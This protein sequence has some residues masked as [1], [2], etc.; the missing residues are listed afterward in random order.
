[1][2]GIVDPGPGHA[3]PVVVSEKPVGPADR[4]DQEYRRMGLAGGGFAKSNRPHGFVNIGQG[5]NGGTSVREPIEGIVGGDPEF[6]RLTKY[7]PRHYPLT[8]SVG[9]AP[10]DRNGVHLGETGPAVCADIDRHGIAIDPL[11]GIGGIKGGGAGTVRGDHGA[12]GK[13]G[14]GCP[15]PAEGRSIGR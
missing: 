9:V 13:A 1:V 12:A 2:G 11:G 15:T 5:D 14:A 6:T 4:P 8:I 10:I 7:R 3:C